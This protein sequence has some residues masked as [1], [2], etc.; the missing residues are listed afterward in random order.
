MSESAAKAPA[1]DSIRIRPL[2]GALGADV[3]GV[4]L[5]V[6]NDATFA[7][8]REAFLAHLV[9]VFPEQRITP[10]QQIAFTARFGPVEAH[11]L[12]TRG[13]VK[14]HPEVLVLENSK[15]RPGL[16]N[17]FWHSDISYAVEPPLGSALYALEVPEGCGD[18]MFCNMYVA[19]EGLSDGMRRMLGR[20]TAMHTGERLI[21]RNKAAAVSNPA[22]V[23]VSPEVEHPVV[24]T[25]PETGRKALYVNPYYTS[26]FADM[27]GAESRPL[28]DFLAAQATRPENVYRHRWRQGDLVLWD[29]RCTMHYAVYDYDESQVRRMHRTTAA[30]DR[31][32]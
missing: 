18:T 19:H 21:E 14:G 13:T 25:H 4:D 22:L 7:A 32:V 9:L 15:R 11:P 27:S 1:Q 28:L 29:N 30:G 10:A 24:R 2:S 17:D 20:L 5:A 6:L 3:S 26:R 12:R 23:E 8:V 16:R 31:P